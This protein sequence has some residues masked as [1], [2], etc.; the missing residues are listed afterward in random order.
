MTRDSFY[1]LRKRAYRTSLK[2]EQRFR[3]K[4]QKKH[5]QIPGNKNRRTDDTWYDVKFPL[6]PLFRWLYKVISTRESE[7]N[8]KEMLQSGTEF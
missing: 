4:K 2:G 3:N 8:K 1:T 7:L 6:L 5:L